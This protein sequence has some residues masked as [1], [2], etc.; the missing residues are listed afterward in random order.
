MTEDNTP[1]MAIHKTGY[2]WITQSFNAF[3]RIQQRNK[4]LQ[5]SQ[6]I[7]ATWQ[8][9]PLEDLATVSP[10]ARVVLLIPDNETVFRQQRFA[11]DLVAEKNL[12]EAISLNIE[13]WSPYGTDCTHLAI[14]KKQKQHWIVA[15]WLWRTST[16]AHLLKALPEASCTH[17][18]P[19][20]A[21]HCGRVTTAE[22]TVLITQI[23]KK[24]AYLYLEK[25]GIP[26]TLSWADSPASITRFWRSLGADIQKIKQITLD[27][28][29]LTHTTIEL[30]IE[31]EKITLEKITPRA[32]WLKAAQCPGVNDWFNPRNW[33]KP[34]LAILSL[35]ITWGAV[36]AILLNQ[37]NQQIENLIKQSKHSNQKVITQQQKIEDSLI[38]LT[39]Y[40]QLK[41]QQQQV[42]R[43]LAELSERIPQNIWLDAIQLDQRW[44]DMRGRGK[45]VIRLMTK[46]ETL[47][48]AADIILL[49]DVRPDVRSGDEQFQIRIILT[50]TQ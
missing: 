35:L 26:N 42:E 23:E 16:Q 37:K 19:E 46:L 20:L 21:W 49:N 41:N 15:I 25:E 22:P 4:T 12:A 38:I 5:A 29:A 27:T 28:P 3:Y 33:L 24:Y 30:P 40:A 2:A 13:S 39:H 9:I 36:D 47:P 11:T 32:K 45:D 1:V 14:Y 7:N 44:L 50:D 43:I 10:L 18:M 6:L 34:A 17:I 48:E 8:Q 31:A